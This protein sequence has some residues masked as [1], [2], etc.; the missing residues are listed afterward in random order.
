MQLATRGRVL[1]VD[2]EPL[3][4]KLLCH[5]LQSKGFETTTA[6]SGTEA[7]QLLAAAPADIILLDV[8]IGNFHSRSSSRLLF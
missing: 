7:L 2:D 8:M 3:N 6:H 1:L 4:L 5:T